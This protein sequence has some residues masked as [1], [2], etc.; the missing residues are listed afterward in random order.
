MLFLLLSMVVLVVPMGYV[1]VGVVLVSMVDVILEE[2]IKLE[3][4]SL[5]N[6]LKVSICNHFVD[7]CWDYMTNH[8]GLAIRFVL[9]RILQPHL[10]HLLV[11]A[12]L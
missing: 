4:V 10:E 7:Y 1:A 2:V 8:L 3:V 12:Q 5:A 9:R 6:A 11:R